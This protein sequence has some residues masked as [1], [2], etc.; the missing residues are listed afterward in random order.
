MPDVSSEDGTMAEDPVMQK[1]HC[2]QAMRM[3][4]AS[5]ISGLLGTPGRQ[6]QCLA[7][8]TRRSNLQLQSIR[9][10]LKSAEMNLF[11]LTKRDDPARQ[12][13]LHAGRAALV[14]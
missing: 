10:R 12:T 7:I 1:L 3:L 6:V 9:P 11:T 13:G 14:P 8:W 5:F 4:L 2:D